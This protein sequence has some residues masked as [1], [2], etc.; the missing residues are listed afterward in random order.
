MMI[1]TYENY[2]DLSLSFVM[3]EMV[4]IMDNVEI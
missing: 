4:M 1:A 2:H 3:F